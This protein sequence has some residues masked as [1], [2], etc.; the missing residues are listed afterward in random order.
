MI[1]S[2]A[3]KDTEKLWNRKRVAKFQRIERKA[4]LK[5]LQLNTA[6]RLEDLQVPPGNRLEK[7]VGDRAG[8]H[9]IAIN[10]QYRVCFVWTPGGPRNLEIVEYH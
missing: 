1:Q 7:L 10:M 8:Q 2:F 5:L 4:R 9:S 3:S 6:T